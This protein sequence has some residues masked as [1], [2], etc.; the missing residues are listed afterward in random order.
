V[1]T[2]N[3]LKAWL[4]DA[5]RDL[6]G[7]GRISQ[8]CRHIWEHHEQELKA[9]GDLF[10]TWQYAMRWAGQELQKERRLSKAGKN[11]TWYLTP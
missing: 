10:Y 9:S 3:D 8:I 11:Y 2:K 1:V 7:S 4:L 6:G 5:L